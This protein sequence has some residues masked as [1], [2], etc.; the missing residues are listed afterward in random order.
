MTLDRIGLA[1][2]SGFYSLNLDHVDP[3]TGKTFSL[4]IENQRKQQ[5]RDPRYNVYAIALIKTDRNWWT[6]VDADSLRRRQLSRDL[7][8]PRN[9][10]R[11]TEIFY[12]SVPLSNHPEP[13]FDLDPRQDPER[14]MKLAERFFKKEILD[15]IDPIK[16]GHL[17]V[18]KPKKSVNQPDPLKLLN[19]KIEQIA[20]TN[21]LTC[22][23]RAYL[24]NYPPACQVLSNYYRLL[25]PALSENV[26]IAY[27]KQ[28]QTFRDQARIYP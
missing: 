5:C 27:A 10:A 2:N 6:V 1:Y 15:P 8:D 3:L 17:L 25:A 20:E 24:L 19:I 11:I 23:E 28:L 18:E 4:L 22:L 21:G 16:M 13:K 12:Y 9:G 14:Y 26:A 7:V